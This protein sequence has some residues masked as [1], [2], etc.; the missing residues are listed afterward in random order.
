MNMLMFIGML[1]FFNL[2][3]ANVAMKWYWE[4][5]PV[6]L[7]YRLRKCIVVSGEAGVDQ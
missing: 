1:Y 6:Y 5:K 4:A 7:C 2:K 3:G